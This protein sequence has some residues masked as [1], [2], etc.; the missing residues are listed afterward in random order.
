[1]AQEKYKNI[2]RGVNSRLD[3]MQ[4]SFLRVKL[5]YLNKESKYSQEVGVLYTNGI[6]N[7]DVI[8]PIDK[9]ITSIT[10]LDNHIFHLYAIQTNH[11]YKLQKY[12]PSNGVHTLIHYLIPPSYQMVYKDYLRVNTPIEKSIHKIF[13][14]FQIVQS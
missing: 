5:R 1:M 6:N 13:L 9:N 14:V 8:L 4:A 10:N 3:E 11:R 7:S 12:L 2:F